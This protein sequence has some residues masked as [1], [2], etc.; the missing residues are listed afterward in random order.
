MLYGCHAGIVALRAV[1]RSKPKEMPLVK[2]ASDAGAPLCLAVTRRVGFCGERGSCGGGCGR[3]LAN[4][5]G[6]RIMR[7]PQILAVEDE[8]L[9]VQMI[10]SALRLNEDTPRIGM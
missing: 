10:A 2:Y 8:D 4:P 7:V 1:E 3:C 9:S 6:E 5:L